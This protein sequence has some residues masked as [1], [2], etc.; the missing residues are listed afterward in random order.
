[1]EAGAAPGGPPCAS[2][3]DRNGSAQAVNPAN[4]ALVSLS[5]RPAE[6]ATRLTT[7]APPRGP[8]QP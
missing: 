5:P 6:F 2:I 8:K 1:M 4:L 7:F 3:T